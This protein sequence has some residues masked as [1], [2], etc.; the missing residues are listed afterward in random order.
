MHIDKL[1]RKFEYVLLQQ[2]S[3][4]NNSLKISKII[5]AT[6]KQIFNINIRNVLQ[7]KI[8]STTDFF[9][10]LGVSFFSR[11]FCSLI[12]SYIEEYIVSF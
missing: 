7:K 6:S 8:S 11:I 4:N 10:K 1:R 2:K 12:E 3:T 5:E 9:I